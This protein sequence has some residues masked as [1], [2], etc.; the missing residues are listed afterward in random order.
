METQ[1]YY[2]GTKRKIFALLSKGKCVFEEDLPNNLPKQ[3]KDEIDEYITH[4]ANADL[5]ITNTHFSRKLKGFDK[6][7]ELKPKNIR[8]FYFF[9]VKSVV[10][11]SACTKKPKKANR[12]DYERAEKIIKDCLSEN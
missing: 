3:T 7:Y 11:I 2:V 12:S 9:F 5:P 1:L 10:L 8:I 6:L 4:L